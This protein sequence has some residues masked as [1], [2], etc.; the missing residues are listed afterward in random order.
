MALILVFPLCAGIY[1]DGKNEYNRNAHPIFH[2]SRLLP[3]SDWFLPDDQAI[4][5]C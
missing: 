4:A 3:A 2:S 1:R 5:L